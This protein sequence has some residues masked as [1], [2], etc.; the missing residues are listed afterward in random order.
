MRILTTITLAGAI[1]AAPA[2]AQNRLDLLEDSRLWIEGTS[3]LHDWKCSTG[4]LAASVELNSGGNS[5]L[6]AGSLSKVNV[7]VPVKSLACGKD[8]MDENMFKALKADDFPTITYKLVRYDVLPGATKDSAAIRAVG[9]L[10]IAGAT[11][12]IVMDVATRRSGSKDARGTGSVAFLMSD[13]GIK[14]PV[15]MLGMLKT[16]DRI[17]VGFDIHTTLTPVVAAAWDAALASR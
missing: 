3:T 11:R 4:K 1:L 7:T 16:G 9:H 8:K 17:T 13:F 10:T 5:V 14:P 15:V 2:G 12:E 6:G